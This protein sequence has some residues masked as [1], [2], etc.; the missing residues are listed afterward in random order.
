MRISDP[1]RFSLLQCPR[2]KSGSSRFE[3]VDTIGS[4]APLS[5]RLGC[6]RFLYRALPVSHSLNT[7]TA[8]KQQ[9]W[10]EKIYITWKEGQI[11]VTG[12]ARLRK[13]AEERWQRKKDEERKTKTIEVV[14]GERQ[15][16]LMLRMSRSSGKMV[17][18]VIV[19]LGGQEASVEQL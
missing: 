15:I 12:G 4:H 2:R 7:V 18:I 9:S 3:M 14:M 17:T 19:S 6:V 13:R 16:F 1:L 11:R 8:S 10:N 5:A